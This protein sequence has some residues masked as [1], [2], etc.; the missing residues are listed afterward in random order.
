MQNGRVIIAID[1]RC[2]SGKTTLAARLAE[3]SGG[4][5]LHMDDFFLQPWQRT[6]ARLKEAGGNVDYERFLEEV[7]APLHEGKPFRYRPYD[8][9]KAQIMEPITMQPGK[10]TIIEGTYSCHPVLWDY[11][12]FRI[13]MTVNPNEQIKRIKE[14]N[15]DKIAD[16]EKRWIPMEEQYFSAFNIG[17]RCSCAI[18]FAEMA[19]NGEYLL[20][21]VL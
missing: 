5:V 8:C 17:S 16:F 4:S 19:G 3:C 20:A 9:R 12:D 21:Q 2:G 6:D 15:P 1:G 10:V 7:L 18:E 14:R 11:Y 13:F